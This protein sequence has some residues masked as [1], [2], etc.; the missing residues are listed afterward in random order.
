MLNLKLLNTALG[1]VSGDEFKVL[2]FIANTLSMKKEGSTRIYRELIAD[3]LGWL[4][5]DKS[6]YA[7]NKVSKITESLV[8]KGY[9]VK[10]EVYSS[11]TKSVIYYSLPSAKKCTKVDDSE[12]KNVPNLPSE[13]QK[14]VVLN[15]NEKEGIKLKTNY[16]DQK[17]EKEKVK[18]EIGSLC[19]PSKGAAP[20]ELDY[21]NWCK[22]IKER[23]ELVTDSY[24]MSVTGRKMR[25]EFEHL[26]GALSSKL[27]KYLTEMV[28]ERK[29]EIEVLMASAPTTT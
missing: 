27:N 19:T 1:E 23:L 25:E 20:M 11:P 13:M 24:E 21:D 22:K 26:P 2:Y 3:R 16:L 5:N 8:K 18:T 4:D 10:N 12:Q 28:I 17:E 9:L 14:N 15:N 7:L 6:K 29:K